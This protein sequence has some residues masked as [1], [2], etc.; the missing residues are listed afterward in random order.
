MIVLSY[1]N[2]RFTIEAVAC[3]TDVTAA[4]TKSDWKHEWNHEWNVIE[5]I[6]KV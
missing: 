6:G 4:A 3:Q 2:E 5:N 1:K